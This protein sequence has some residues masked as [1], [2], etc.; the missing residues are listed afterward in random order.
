MWREGAGDLA[1]ASRPWKKGE[2]VINVHVVEAVVVYPS[3]GRTL[4]STVRLLS[5]QIRIKEC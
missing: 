2:R 1:C 4:Y 5:I 3:S